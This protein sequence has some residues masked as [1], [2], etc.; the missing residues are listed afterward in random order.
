MYVSSQLSGRK[1]IAVIRS[2][3]N[4]EILRSIEKELCEK[5][6]LAK[7]CVAVNPEFLREA[8]AIHDFFHP[9]FTIV[10]GGDAETQKIVLSTYEK[11]PSKKYRVSIEAAAI[12]KL[13]C[14]AFHATKIAFANEIGSL[15][16][17]H[18]VNANEL[19]TIFSEDTKLNCSAS[20]LK[21]GF[22]FGGSC[23]SKDLSELSELGQTNGLN[24]L[25]KAV[26]KSNESLIN[27]VCKKIGFSKINCVAL[28]G[29][30]FKKGANDLRDSPYVKLARN[31]SRMGIAVNIY[32][33]DYIGEPGEIAQ[34][35]DSNPA[36][37]KVK[38]FFN[39]FEALDAAGGVVIVKSFSKLVDVLDRAK[40]QSSE[41]F[42]I[43][44]ILDCSL[45]N[46][47]VP[48]LS[49]EMSE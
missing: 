10:G 19:M 6:A 48:Q 33:E 27:I 35:F 7:V 18:G 31:L 22:A 24:I 39:A 14:N 2:T 30:T 41:I 45:N 21:P 42:D 43:G 5:Y 25:L 47:S 17:V 23:L 12:L 29:I 38:L 15:C 20:Y 36:D 49:V 13:S 11:I 8:T 40:K 9:P 37:G 1:K 3:T 44:R 4:P 28:F 34:A 16:D 46:V 26:L 32:D